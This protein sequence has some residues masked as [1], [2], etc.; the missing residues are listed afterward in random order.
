MVNLFYLFQHTGLNH[1]R[2]VVY[3]FAQLDVEELRLFFYLLLK[4]LLADTM[5]VLEDQPTDG[6]HTSVFV[7]FST[8]VTVSNLSWRKRTGFLH[9]VE[10]IFKTFDEFH[11]KPFLNPLMMIVVRILESCMLNIMGDNSKRGD[12]LGDNSLGDSEAHEAS[13]LVPD[14]LAVCI[15]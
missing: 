3:F 11:A 8:L 4:P 13:T 10:D 12:S 14:S 1:R 15:H 2:A 6:F 5:E 9:V 7:N